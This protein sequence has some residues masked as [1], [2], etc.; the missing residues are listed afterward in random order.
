LHG[1]NR[2]IPAFRWFDRQRKEIVS[3]SGPAYVAELEKQISNGEGL[4]AH[5]GA[6][7]GN[8]FSGDADFVMNT[9]STITDVSRL[10]TSE[11]YAYFLHPYNFIRTLLLF[12]WDIVTEIREFRKARKTGAYPI[13]D[14]AKRGGI[15]PVLRAFT[16]VIMLDLNIY[17]LI[18]DIFAGVPAAYA[19]FVG[20]D[21]VAH[22]S[23]IESED[24]YKVLKKI[25]RQFGRLVKLAEQAPRPYHFV[26]LSDHGQTQG[27]TFKQ[28]YHMTLEEYLQQLAT[29]K[30]DVQ[31]A[32]D[33]HE[34]WKHLNVF[35]T[36]TINKDGALQKPMRQALSKHTEDDEVSLGPEAEIE[37]SAETEFGH[38]V[39]LASGNLGLIYSVR[40]NERA[41]LEAIEKIYPGMLE[42][43]A[44]HEG[45]GFLMINSEEHGPVVIGAQG[46]YYLDADRLE[47]QNPLEGFGP[48]IVH[49]LNRTNSFIDAPDIL[50]NSFFDPEK[51]EGAAFEEL[52][53]FHGGLGGYQTQPFLLYPAEWT[54]EDETILGAEAVY[55]FLKGHLV[56]LQVA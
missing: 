21:E 29:E 30:Y 1:N 2:N 27:A 11:F 19:T 20:Y 14:K 17:T 31:G 36:E 26:V 3:S 50:V 5:G 47:G 13:S 32:I 39:A 6:S 10:K 22:H 49:H 38:L 9:A 51:Q 43:L 45:V 53:G 56:K 40:L 35:L 28:R 24:A 23:G 44:E 34:D 25:D 48:N 42:G 16:T 7:R 18:G 55:Q 52:I 37:E 46:R 12:V 33:V 4:L 8:L 54:R 15:Y 41:T